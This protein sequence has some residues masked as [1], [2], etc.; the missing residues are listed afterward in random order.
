VLR[1]RRGETEHLIPFVGAYVDRVDLAARTILV[2][3]GLDY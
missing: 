1:V 3:W 2:D